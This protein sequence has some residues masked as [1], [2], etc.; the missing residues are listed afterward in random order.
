MK[1]LRKEEMNQMDLPELE[2]R[3]NKAFN[4]IIKG[5]NARALRNMLYEMLGIIEFKRR[6]ELPG[7]EIEL[8]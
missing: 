5:K 3:K 8:A 6:L 1:L 2:I 7:L 4:Q